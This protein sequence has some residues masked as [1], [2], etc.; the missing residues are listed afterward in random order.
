MTVSA[1][2]LTVADDCAPDVARVLAGAGLRGVPAGATQATVPYTA[3]EVKSMSVDAAAAA[4][5]YLSGDVLDELWTIDRRKAVRSAIVGMWSELSPAT[6][7]EAYRWVEDGEHTTHRNGS[8]DGLLGRMEL[9]Q[10]LGLADGH[11][12]ARP[13][14]WAQAIAAKCS[15][16]ESLQAVLDRLAGNSTS[17]HLLGAALS[18][19]VDGVDVDTAVELCGDRRTTALERA[20]QVTAALVDMVLGDA[21]LTDTLMG[22]PR[23]GLPMGDDVH[24][25]LLD[26][27][28]SGESWPETV[29][30]WVRLGGDAQDAFDVSPAGAADTLDAAAAASLVLKHGDNLDEVWNERLQLRGLGAVGEASWVVNALASR[31]VNTTVLSAALERLDGDARRAYVN[32]V[33]E[34][35]GRG[36]GRC[37]DFGPL[38]VKSDA[39][40]RFR[41][42]LVDASTDRDQVART[43]AELAEELK[44]PGTYGYRTLQ[45]HGRRLLDTVPLPPELLAAIAGNAEAHA[46]LEEGSAANEVTREV[47]RE[48]VRTAVRAEFAL[49]AAGDLNDVLDEAL[50]RASEGEALVKHLYHFATLDAGHVETLVRANPHAATE[51]VLKGSRSNP[52][53]YEHRAVALEHGSWDALDLVSSFRALPATADERP[54]L[55]AALTKE[56]YT[57]KRAAQE[58]V[59]RIE[60][61]PAELRAAFEGNTQLL[62][63]WAQGTTA[64]PYRPELLAE[65]LDLVGSLPAGDR[66]R[67]APAL[68]TLPKGRD[69][70]TRD[71]DFLAAMQSAG[72]RGDEVVTGAARVLWEICRDRLGENAIAWNQ[73]TT[74]VDAWPGTLDELLTVCCA[75]AGI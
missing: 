50:S 48:V 54:L 17:D 16:R 70:L 36:T 13:S 23:H 46:W 58:A 28:A 56:S 35:F 22:R 5:A 43:V 71:R 27:L 1:V 74:Q 34:R 15:G 18:G 42:P 53:S 10:V 39:E 47:V 19:L 14:S 52:L 26:R 72:R 57:R 30:M 61:D 67:M 38:I 32:A 41:L 68:D 7:L 60:L 12:C 59:A 62:V 63:P 2:I 20:P 75:V 66:L 55:L 3:R 49:Q 6:A 25:L 69:L 37:A 4:V 33:A 31:C 65:M 8:A 21:E 11:W 44:H 45:E 29:Q 24:Q 51:L 40:L 9:D 73:F 64:T